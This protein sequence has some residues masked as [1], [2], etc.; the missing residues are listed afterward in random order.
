MVEENLE[1]L[2]SLKDELRSSLLDLKY[3]DKKRA[4]LI[5]VDKSSITKVVEVLSKISGGEVH[6][7]TI[8]G[9]DLGESDVELT[10]FFWLLPQRLR[11]IAKT[12]LPKND[13][14]VQS[15]TKNVPAA[16]LYE[17][18]VYEMFGVVFEGHP[19][20][21]KLF[22]PEDWPENVYPLRRS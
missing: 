2:N 16:M 8:S 12:K 15:I 10:Y 6:L 3:L 17:R 5:L 13:L 11:I 21:E 7:T 18:E 1:V 19:K 20:L 14:R 4:I 9:A 22:L